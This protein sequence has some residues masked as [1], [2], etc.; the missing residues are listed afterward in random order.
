MFPIVRTR[1]LSLLVFVVYSNF[2]PSLRLPE[3]HGIENEKL[4]LLSLE[5]THKICRS[6][7]VHL[8]SSKFRAIL[9][10]GRRDELISCKITIARVA[11]VNGREDFNSITSCLGCRCLLHNLNGTFNCQDINRAIV[12]FSLVNNH[13]C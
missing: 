7:Y 9:V 11:H 3:R 13:S 12:L 6:K 10:F 8:K 1:I 4:Y 2:F 5:V